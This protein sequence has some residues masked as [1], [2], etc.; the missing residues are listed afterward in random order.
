[1]K[2]LQQH[3]LPP[4]LV[5][6]YR[7]GKANKRTNFSVIPMRSSR[8]YKIKISKN[9]YHYANL[10]QLS[11]TACRKRAIS[12]ANSRSFSECGLSS[13]DTDKEF[14]QSNG[15][16]SDSI[17]EAVVN[18]VEDHISGQHSQS[19]INEL[20]ALS[21]P[22]IL[23]QAIDPLA[24]LMETAYVG[25]LGP[26]ELASAAVAVSIFNIVSKL[27]NIPL[28][29][30]TTSFVAED[31]SKN[32]SRTLISDNGSWKEKLQDKR[33][34]GD[35][36]EKMRLP[37]V[38]SA[39]L[40]AAGIGLIEALALFLGSGMFL[41]IMGIPPASPMRYPAQ[42]FLSLRALG[43][44]AVVVSLAVQGV[45][46]GFKDTK[47]PVLYVGLGNL[48][49]VVLLPVLVYSFHLGVTGAALA[50]VTSQ[51]ITT[52]LLLWSLSKRAVILPPKIEDLQF[53]GYIKSG[54]MLLGRTMSVLITT[55]LGTSMAARQGPLAMAAH[56]ICLQVWLAVSLLSDAL[57]VSAQALV[58][59][60]LAKFDYKKVKAVTYYVLKTGVLAGIALG[61]G[62]A[63]SFGNLARLFTK[64]PGVLQI[65]K[66][67]VLFVSASQ[68][69]N[70]LAF[71]FDGLH[72][73]VS[74]FSYSAYSMM[75]VGAI[76]SLFLLYAPST[77]GLGGVWAGLTL[78]MSLRMAAGFLRLR[79]KA[80]PWWFLYQE[81]P[82]A[83]LAHSSDYSL[84][85]GADKG[86][87]AEEKGESDELEYDYAITD[88]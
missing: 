70:A 29:N 51:Y 83:E 3:G 53:G 50:T 59:S 20:L 14:D 23:G 67:G 25:R 9:F 2:A 52:F 58:A 82:K 78:F 42:V 18:S 10:T 46:R 73:G 26:V 38:S 81:E 17:K 41:N 76:S 85:V 64:D 34:S 88:E 22:A 62:L 43:A 55:T 5:A 74:D 84:P 13:D 11:L 71:I 1:M 44:P 16:H 6:K 31:I 65:V 45:F 39:L 36:A 54:G 86:L 12:V 21:L 47:T 48:S 19:V 37:S 28:L 15:H 30:I 80:G 72:Y 68:P 4:G 66:T 75:V 69:I 61:V 33:I 79:W 87:E 40:L 35:S 8:S 49:A 57:A 60:S 24:Q 77:F 56:Q 7:D 27:F 32:Y 63:A